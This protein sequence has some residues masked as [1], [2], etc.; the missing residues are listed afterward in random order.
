MMSS[1]RKSVITAIVVMI[2]VAKEELADTNMRGYGW[3]RYA[4][5]S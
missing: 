2:G 3:V 4:R 1:G 5:T